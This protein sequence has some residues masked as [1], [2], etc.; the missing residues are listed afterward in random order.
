MINLTAYINGFNRKVLKS[1][2]PDSLRKAQLFATIIW[3][4]VALWAIVGFS[5]AFSIYQL[6][7]VASIVTAIMAAGFIFMIERAIILSNGG[8]AIAI[9]RV[10]LG[11]TI[12]FVGAQ[13]IDAVLFKTDMVAIANANN[14][15]QAAEFALLNVAEFDS[16]IEEETKKEAQLQ[17]HM[18][19]SELAYTQEIDG[20]GGSGKANIGPIAREKNAVYQESKLDFKNQ[21]EL[22]ISLKDERDTKYNE[23]EAAFTPSVGILVA[24]ENLHML[25]SQNSRANLFYWVFTLLIMVIEFLVIVFKM[26]SNPS[27]LEKQMSYIQITQIAHLDCRLQEQLDYLNEQQALSPRE[28]NVAKF[29]INNRRAGQ[30]I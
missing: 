30:L 27:V 16:R 13:F 29:L 14:Q 20:T 23:A 10:V 22:L 8:K 9:I 4:P 18:R 17:K 6:G 2:T 7:V 28:K 26:S 25:C 15:K 19:D 21:V 3:L 1:T 12:A 11:L 24:L 5:A